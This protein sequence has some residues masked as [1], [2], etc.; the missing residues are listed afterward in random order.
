ML[1]ELYTLDSFPIQHC[2]I[3]N[4]SMKQY[5]HNKKYD[6]NCPRHHINV[7]LLPHHMNRWHIYVGQN[8]HHLCDDVVSMMNLMEEVV[9]VNADYFPCEQQAI[10]NLQLNYDYVIARPAIEVTVA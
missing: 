3:V 6:H 4:V 2:Y 8:R 10:V 9:K 1:N 7:W 5:I